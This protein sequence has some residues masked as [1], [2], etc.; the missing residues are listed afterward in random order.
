VTSKRTR[1]D[2]PYSAD[3]MYALVAEIERYPEFLPWCVALRIVERKGEKALEFATADMIVAYGVFR[4]KFRSR[5]TFDP[6]ARRI[7]AD[8]VEGP[9][10]LLKN[11]WSFEDLPSGGSRVDFFIHFEFASR[12]LQAAAQSAFERIFLRMSDAFIDRAKAI[13]G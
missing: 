7:D 4:E 9:F 12:V 2:V 13:Y 1:S 3:Q 6:V 8:Y 5:V 10:R 11:E